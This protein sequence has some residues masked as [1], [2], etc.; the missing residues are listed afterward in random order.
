MDKD[1]W[2]VVILLLIFIMGSFGLYIYQK[3]RYKDVYF[4]YNGFTV[5]NKVDESGNSLYQIKIYVKDD[6]QPYL[7]STRYSPLDLEDISV[8]YSRNDVLKKEIFIT[9]D[10]KASAISVL[11]ATEISKITGNYFIYGVP[12]HGALTEPVEGKKVEVKTCNDV[13][14]DQA[15][16]LLKQGENSKIYSENGCVILE[17]KS[18]YDLIKVANKLILNLLGVMDE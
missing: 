8:S 18:E 14:E 16:I 6:K 3:N 15:I 17:G 7:I 10:S 11:A 4:D 13:T 12:T 5:H 2:V 1:K 9:M